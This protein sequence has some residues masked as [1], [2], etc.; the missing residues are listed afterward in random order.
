MEQQSYQKHA[1]FVV[2]YHRILAPLLL[3]ILIGSFVNVYESVGDEARLYSATLISALTVAVFIAALYARVFALGVQDRVIRTEENLR[4]YLL[5]GKPLDPRLT[6]KQIVGL[7]FASDAE[8]PTLAERAAKENLAL[9]D[10]KRAI[11]SWRAD[12]NRI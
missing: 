1:R 2:G 11:K 3:L 9:D 7:R 10:I 8:F 5:T 12:H 6:V 4:H